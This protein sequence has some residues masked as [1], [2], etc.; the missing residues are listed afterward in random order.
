MLFTSCWYDKKDNS[1]AANGAPVKV[2]AAPDPSLVEVTHPEQ[3]PLVKVETRKVPGQVVTNGAV[4]WDV[5]RSVPVNSI[6]GGRVLEVRARL[7]DDVRKGQVLL[8]IDSPD[9]AMALAD[10]R[11]AVSSVRLAQKAYDRTKALYEHKAAPL[12]DVQQAEEDLQKAKI[13]L[14]TAEERIRIIGG[15]PDQSS[16]RFEVKA[17]ITGTIVE[18][19]TTSGAAVKSLDNSPNLFTIADLSRVWVLGDLYENNLSDVRLGD[20]AEVRLNAYPDRHLTGRV[21]NISRILDPATRTAK[22][23]LELDNRQGLL[24]PGMFATARFISRSEK[25]RTVVPMSAILRLHDKSWVFRSE[26]ERRFRRTEVQTGPALSEG[27]QEILS[28]LSAGDTVVQNAL[29]FASTASQGE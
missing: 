8:V 23:R 1:A 24:R 2:E 12:K 6:A 4:A 18:Q 11:R 3:F 28:G 7:G 29:Q 13:D 22:V 17:P 14:Q 10:H 26:G 25:I 21:V 15:T 5:S 20:H 9:L 27:L 16:P 19:N